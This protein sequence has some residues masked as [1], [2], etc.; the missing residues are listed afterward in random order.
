MNDLLYLAI[1]LACL[2]ATFGVLKVC[3]VLMP[4]EI[5]SKP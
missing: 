1:F 4:A 2:L 5:R 3:G